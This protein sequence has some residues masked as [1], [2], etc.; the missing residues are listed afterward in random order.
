MVGG[1]MARR[2]AMGQAGPPTLAATPGRALSR[3]ALDSTL[4]REDAVRARQD[5]RARQAGPGAEP[6]DLGR[7]RERIDELMQDAARF[8]SPG[9]VEQTARGWLARADLDAAPSVRDALRLAG[10]V[11]MAT[12][13]ALF[14][15][16]ISG[17]TAFDRLTRQRPG[18]KADEAA[19]LA[20]LRRAQF[21]LLRVEAAG[22]G[23]A[24][25][26]DL[27]GGEAL[28]VADETIGPDWA[29]RALVGRLAPLGDGWHV[30][31]G[32]VTSL[33]EAGLAVA[34]A[35]VRPGRRGLVTPQRCAEAVYAH[36]VRTGPPNLPEL[37]RLLDEIGDE[38]PDEASELDRVARR[39]AEPGAGREAEDVRRVRAESN[40]D[41]TLDMIASV[42]NT[43]AH[44]VHAL[45]DAYAEIVRLQ[46]ETVHRRHAAGSGGFGLDAVAAA[47]EAEIQRGGLPPGA[48]AVFDD[49][50]RRLG[51]SASKPG[52]QDAELERLIGRI[53]GLRAKTVEQGCTEQE[54]LAAAAKV[55]ELLDRYGLSLSELDLQRQACDGAAVETS[56]KRVGPVDDCVPAVAAFF[57]CRAWGEKAAAGT[58]RYVFFGLPADVAAARY[59]YDLVERAFDTETALFRAGATYAAMPSGVRRTASNSFQIGLARGIAAKLRTLREAREAALRGSGGR[60]LVVAKA[61][62]VEA[63]LAKLGLQFRTR[64][65]SGGRR[66]L[67]DAYEEGHEAGL[68]FDYTPGV[69][70]DRHG[71][72]EG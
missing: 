29:G 38:W 17:H 61:D 14:A 44:G 63:E 30:V 47:L 51:S 8:I 15:P 28:D 20:A 70:H 55:A 39:W 1:S 16:S 65:G 35:Y 3:P 40:V 4:D 31:A 32:A 68:G 21:R 34:M 23:G 59:L 37:D 7:V 54:A 49:A 52:A 58:L 25:C 22:G 33:D 66:V 72:A 24:R 71:G 46:L 45:S 9:K 62:V 64:K 36:A 26:L 43:R 11:M 60:D 41:A 27:A 2:P 69:G 56:R 53:Q 42:V 12:D 6:A 18:L 48:R 19:A 5:S 50:R 57:D 10:A 13:L 67:G